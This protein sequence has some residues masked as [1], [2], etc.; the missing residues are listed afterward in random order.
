VHPLLFA[1]RSGQ[2]RPLDP[3]LLPVPLIRTLPAVAHARLV[4][5]AFAAVRPMLYTR[6]PQARLRMIEH[7]GVMTAAMV[8][9]RQPII[10]AFRR[11]G[12]DTLLGAMDLRGLP[13][14]FLF[15][16]RRDDSAG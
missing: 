1:D 16:L 8:Y 13:S 11:V 10:D 9:D 7:R 12:P 4:R 2:P 6:T 15:V 5:L 14:P 3:T